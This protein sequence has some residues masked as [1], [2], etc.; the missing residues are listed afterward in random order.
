MRKRSHIYEEIVRFVEANNLIDRPFRASEI[1]LPN[2][3]D[4]TR[5]FLYKHSNPNYIG[6]FTQFFNRIPNTY[7]IHFTLNLNIRKLYFQ[8]FPLI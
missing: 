1:L 4:S 3:G 6:Q 5:N 8:L 2:R 7:P